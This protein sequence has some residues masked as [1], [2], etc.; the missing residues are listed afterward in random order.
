MGAQVGPQAMLGTSPSASMPGCR[1]VVLLPPTLELELG[2]PEGWGF[3]E[4]IT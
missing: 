3:L 1:A 4:L 2:R